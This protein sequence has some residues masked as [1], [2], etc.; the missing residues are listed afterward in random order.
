MSNGGN[1]FDAAVA[2]SAVL[3][4]VEP[5]HSG[6]GGGG[7]WLLYDA[8]QQKNLLIDGR[9]VAPLSATD[10]MYLDE[11]MQPI[12][13]LSLTGGKAAAIPGEPAALVYISKNFGQLQLADVLKPAIDLAENGFE[14]DQ[15]YVDFVNMGDRLK[16][17][18]KFPATAKIFL[19]QNKPF[20]VGERL[21]QKD[22]ANTLKQLAQKG[23]D[24]FYK[25]EIAEK[26]VKGVNQSG[27]IWQLKDLNNYQIKLRKPIIGHYHGM[28]IITTPLPSAGGIGLITMLNI[29]ETYKLSQIPKLLQ[30]HYIIEA[31]RLAFWQRSELMGDPDFEQVNVSQLLSKENAL[32]LKQ[33]IKEIKATENRTLPEKPLQHEQKHTTHFSIIDRQGNKV[34]ATLTI[35][36]I[37]GSSVVA[38]GTGVLLNDE[39]D[40]FSIKQNVKNVFGLSHGEKNMIKPGKRP[41]SSMAPTFLETSTQSAILGTPGGSRIPTMILLASLN[42]FEGGGAISMVSKMRFHHQYKP[43]WVVYE[44]N[45]LTEDIQRG[46]QQMGYRLMPLKQYYGDMQ[47][48]TWNFGLNLLTA[49]AD[50]RNIGEAT[51][52]STMAK[53]GYGNQH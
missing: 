51:V 14:V 30:T 44:P 17:M 28:K 25:G 52:V 26:L 46:L 43:D 19:N 50:P 42:F 11:N 27:G 22:L 9:E 20:K 38:D 21:F 6:L 37:F 8:A 24:G 35:N 34:A 47:A 5:Y 45:S 3:G 39:M 23:R 40:D 53:S 48:I 7:F 4:V 41:L 49:T 1:A 33:Y 16:A 18:K 36:Y 15:Q 12:A 31:M 10:D 2:I 32:F 29:L 13:G